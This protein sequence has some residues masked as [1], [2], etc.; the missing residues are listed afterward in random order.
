MLRFTEIGLFLVPFVLYLVWWTMGPRTP[1]WAVWLALAAVLLLAA[2]SAWYGLA[3][4]AAPG[5]TYVPA[6]IENGRIV[7]GRDVSP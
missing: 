6:H 4:R 3:E 2:G 7:P 1:R 5:A